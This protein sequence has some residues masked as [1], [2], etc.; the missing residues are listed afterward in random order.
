MHAK[1][2]FSMK[3]PKH[4]VYE[5]VNDHKT[6]SLLVYFIFPSLFSGRWGEGRGKG[7][8]GKARQKD[9]HT[10]HAKTI[11]I[12]VETEVLMTYRSRMT[13]RTTSP[14]CF[15][16]PSHHATRHLSVS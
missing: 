16:E 13:L 6:I 3:H 7:E 11:F 4:V 12:D 5:S 15:H 8:A 14:H 1:F 2:T 10:P 9:I